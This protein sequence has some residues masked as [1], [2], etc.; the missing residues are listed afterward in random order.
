MT[1]T[2]NSILSR[3]IDLEKL[4]TSNPELFDF[5]KL[6]I[7]AKIELLEYSY[8][9]FSELLKPCTWSVNDRAYLCLRMPKRIKSI[10]FTEDEIMSIGFDSYYSDLLNHDFRKFISVRK[11]ESCNNAEKFSIFARFPD[12]VIKNS[13]VPKINLPQLRGL[14]ASF[15]D[16]YVDFTEISAD[17]TVWDSLIKHNPAKY[18]PLA[19]KLHSK[20][21]NITEFRL[22]VATYPEIV[23]HITPALI[24]S[25]KYSSKLWVYILK[26]AAGPDKKKL[27][28][29]PGIEEEIRFGLTAE[30]LSG[31]SQKSKQLTSAM[32]QIFG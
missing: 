16:R 26:D 32:R 18:I 22:L 10:N 8:E 29:Q 4:H 11:Y 13:T 9:I 15:I 19:A 23:S 7:R 28:L 14:S 5:S 27:Q 17:Y 31:K 21:Y 20:I 30:I 1:P 25:S 12:W 6:D 3:C 24:S 2:V